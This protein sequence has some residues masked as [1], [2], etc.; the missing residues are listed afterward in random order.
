MHLDLRSERVFPRETHRDR[1]TWNWAE[2]A[3]ALRS[4]AFVTRERLL[5]VCLVFIVFQVWMF[6]LDLV[7]VLSTVTVSY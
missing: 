1:T 4:H 3:K 5:R 7:P 6:F 2:G